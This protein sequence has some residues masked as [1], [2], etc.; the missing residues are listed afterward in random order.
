MKTLQI[1]EAE[2]EVG[3]LGKGIA[4]TEFKRSERTSVRYEAWGKGSLQRGK[5]ESRADKILIL[6]LDYIIT[7]IQRCRE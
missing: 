6:L 5:M 4:L 3:D 2:M 1:A 7:D